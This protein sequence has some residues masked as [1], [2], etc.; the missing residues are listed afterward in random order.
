MSEEGHTSLR[1]YIFSQCLNSLKIINKKIKPLFS[2]TFQGNQM[3]MREVSLFNE[4]YS[5]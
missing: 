5:S 3:L 2:H 4:K 1:I